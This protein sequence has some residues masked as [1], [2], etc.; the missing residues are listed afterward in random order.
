M[1]KNIIQKKKE[2]YWQKKVI[3]NGDKHATITKL[4]IFIVNIV[5]N[6]SCAIECHSLI[7]CIFDHFFP[8]PVIL[9]MFMPY[10]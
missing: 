2:K 6:Y 8:F 5:Q 3:Y 4:V 1:L 10:P 9:D 7:L